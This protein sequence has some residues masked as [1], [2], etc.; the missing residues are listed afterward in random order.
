MRGAPSAGPRVARSERIIPAD[1]GSTARYRVSVLSAP[2][3]PRGC[4][5][6][7]C[8]PRVSYPNTGSSPR[9]RGAPPCLSIWRAAIRI[10]PA[11][12]GSTLMPLSDMCMIEDH[13]RGCGEHSGRVASVLSSSGSSPR[14]RGAPKQ[15]TVPIVAGRI[16]PADAGSTIQCRKSYRR[17][18]DHPR[19]CGEH[20]I[21]KYQ[22]VV[23]KGSSPR[24]RGAQFTDLAVQI[25]VGIIP[26][27]AGSTSACSR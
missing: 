27:D 5:E 19:G 20:Q 6:H 3:H 21:V 26:A 14:M 17:W 7:P 13:P 10:I 1:A 8:C 4:G 25:E 11:D 12:A 16:I 9:M 22:S 15:I 2:D 23:Q 24:M 18:E